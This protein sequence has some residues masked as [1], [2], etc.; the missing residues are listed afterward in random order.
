M[1]WWERLKGGLKKSTDK[2][3]ESLHH[4]FVKRKLDTETLDALTDAMIL[5]DFGV[6]TAHKIRDTLKKEKFEQDITEEELKNWLSS[7]VQ[8][9]LDPVEANLQLQKNG[10]TVI[11]VVGVNGSG[12]T[13]NIA[14]LAAYYQK[15]GKKVHVAACDTFRAAA[16]AQLSV[17]AKRVGFTIHTTKENGDSAGLAYDALK[18]AQEDQADILFI[19]TAGRLH[20]KTNLMDELKKIARVMKKIDETVPHHTLLVLDATTGQN[21][22]QQ[23]QEFKNTVDVNGLILTKLDGTAKGGIVVAIAEKF[24]TP[25]YFIGVGEQTEDLQ[26][27]KSEDFSKNLFGDIQKC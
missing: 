12:K 20:N 17:W 11:C 26:P 3:T 2:I 22:L 1:Q 27:F 19:D 14:K 5:A 23:M 15:L 16:V 4:V 9:L 25:I 8:T 21:A 13:T 24:Q 10:L 6:E 18:K 7:Y